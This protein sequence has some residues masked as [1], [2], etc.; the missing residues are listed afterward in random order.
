VTQDQQLFTCVLGL[1]SSFVSFVS[2]CSKGCFMPLG[3]AVLLLA[4]IAGFSSSARA[5]ST[6]NGFW[7][8]QS[9]YQI[10]T[11]RF[12][13]GDPSNNNAEGNYRPRNSRGVH[14]GDFKGIE[15]KLDYIKA[16]GATAI[17][18]SPIVLNGH[19]QFHGYAARDFYRVAPHWGSLV[20]L[21]HMIAAAHARSILVID[22]IIVNHGDN[23]IYSTDN[24]YP[25][26]RA[27]PAGYTLKYRSNSRTY[28]PPFDIYNSTY[29]P[30]NNALTN[31]FHNNGD[32]PGYNTP[33]PVELGE[34]SGLD[35]FRT[36]SAY[37][38]SNM[39]EIYKYWIGQAGFDGFRIDTVKHVEMGFWQNWCPLI[40]AYAAT[41]GKPNFFM[42]GEVYDASERKCGSYTGTRSGG[43]FALDSV[44][45]YPLYYKVNSVFASA[46][47]NTRQIEDHY[48]AIAANY[49]PAAQMR[50]VTFLD[51]HDQ[52]RFL[53]VRGATAGR[54][55]V[56]LVFLYTAR[57]IP[58]LYY[59]TEQAFDGTTDPND[60]ED[61]FAG[62]FEQGPSLGDNFNMTHPQFQMVAKLNNFRRL[63]PALQLGSHVNAWNDPRGP[64]LFAYARRLGR[65][66]VFVVFNTS[67]STQTLTN[68][69][70]IFA[71]GTLVVNLF[72]TN[73]VL[74]VTSTPEIPPITVPGT[75]AKVFVAQS[76]WKPLDPVVVSNSPA[77]DA[78]GVPTHSPIVLQF[79]KPMDTNSVQ[80][81]FVTIPPV[82]G[83]FTWS[84]AEDTVTF[85]PSGAGF[86]ALTMVSINV[87]QTAVD[88]ISGN[89]L[90]SPYEMRFKTEASI[91][92][93]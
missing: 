34:L 22:D 88:A 78:T 62:Q 71:A 6:S 72:D 68:R 24:G 82:E 73:E 25:T 84:T 51:N 10:I 14:G 43:A 3:R 53:S 29:T 36:E 46:I 93:R 52:P 44:L 18:I 8:A 26:F 54:L 92:Q 63:Y 90:Y 28:A 91:M 64:G 37:V 9:I 83:T 40:H 5:Q 30:A 15:Q 23:L 17:W 61:M 35:D 81:S 47:G 79:S 33:R 66:E 86:P 20:D 12:F 59:G 87:T 39:A 11:D 16:L 89:A 32:I 70:T 49:D 1:K 48:Q 31:L 55:N 7:Q 58:C 75:T 2:F 85:T 27:P 19:G 76:D 56:A 80:N 77:H 42:F 60:R 38:R 57:G 4:A 13:D 67:T 45:D 69:P 50:L 41:I 65:E 21:Q 74:A